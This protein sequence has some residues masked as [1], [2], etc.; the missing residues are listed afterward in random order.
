MKDVVTAVFGALRSVVHPVSVLTLLGPM[1]AALLLWAGIGWVFWD[2]WTAG[3]HGFIVEHGHY[4]WMANWNMSTIAA[5]VAIVVVV[6]MLV[7]AVLLTALLIATVFA[8][9]V[10]VRHVAQGD[11]AGLEKRHG[12]GF[13][14]SAWNAISAIS[15]FLL[16]WILAIP[17]WLLGPLA[18]VVPLLLS[19]WLNQRLFRYDALAEH[20]D[21]DE[22]KKIFEA[23]RGR[24]FL[25]GL[26]TGL[27]YFI[28]LINLVAPV[29]AALA[30]IHLGLKELER[31]RSSELAI[32]GQRIAEGGR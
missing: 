6:A 26:A 21:A 7:P 1:L 5:W 11:Y 31:L 10:L 14:G 29:F 16:L 22:M 27:V 25:L 19:A 9:P 28:P 20:A 15:L 2:A 3:I 32:P 4:S 12:G 24:L 8:V 30:F 17:L 18:F 23:A 13:A